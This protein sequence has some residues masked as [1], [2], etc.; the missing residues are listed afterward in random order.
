[1]EN[2][3]DYRFNQIILEETME[4]ISNAFVV[5]N[6]DCQN[7]SLQTV[8]S[9]KEMFMIKAEQTKQLLFNFIDSLSQCDY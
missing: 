9:K 8:E 3:T 4:T 5:L 7:G 2:R 1:M 6:A